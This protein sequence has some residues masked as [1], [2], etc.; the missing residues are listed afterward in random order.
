MYVIVITQCIEGGREGKKAE[1]KYLDDTTERREFGTALQI[2][3][4]PI[5]SL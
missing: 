1:E 3:V 5:V 4:P 2:K